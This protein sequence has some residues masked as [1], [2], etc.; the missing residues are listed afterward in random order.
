MDDMHKVVCIGV[1][2]VHNQDENPQGKIPNIIY[3]LFDKKNISFDTHNMDV[4]FEY[5]VGCMDGFVDLHERED[6]FIVAFLFDD[7]LG[8]EDIGQKKPSIMN[9]FN[10]HG[11]TH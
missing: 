9:E 11:F 3:D 5:V 4:M 8:I 6:K 1:V 2:N 7:I 10:S